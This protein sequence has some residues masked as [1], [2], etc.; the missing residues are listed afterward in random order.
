MADKALEEK[1][2]YFNEQNLDASDDETAFPKETYLRIERFLEDT[3]PKPAPPK[4]VKQKSF[5]GPTP[6]ERQAEFEAHARRKREQARENDKTLLLGRP[7]TAPE[8]D[9][10]SSFP[11]AKPDPKQAPKGRA[12]RLKLKRNASVSDLPTPKAVIQD[13]VPFYKKRGVI[14]RELKGGKNVKLAN[15]IAILPEDRQLFKGKV[16]CTFPYYIHSWLC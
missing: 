2:A 9:I 3:E 12:E 1:I 8:A 7:N 13:D 15:D 4:L 10:A 14:P 6:K 5:L 16:I 11:A